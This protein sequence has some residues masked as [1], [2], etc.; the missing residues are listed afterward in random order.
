MVYTLSNF[1]LQNLAWGGSRRSP[2]LR[3]LLPL[4]CVLTA[5]QI[6]K[7]AILIKIWPYGKIQRVHRK[8]F[9]IG[10]QIETTLY[11]TVP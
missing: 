9:N 1:F 8:N 11:V 7:N 2:Q 10:V 4:K 3:Q 6:A 5:S